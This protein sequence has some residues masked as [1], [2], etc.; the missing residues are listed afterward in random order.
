MQVLIWKNKLDEEFKGIIKT[1]NID[2]VRSVTHYPSKD[3]GSVEDIVK[4]LREHNV[5]AAIVDIP[6]EIADTNNVLSV[7]QYASKFLK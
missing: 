3:S 1:D 4:W 7:W 5:S 2:R 6:N